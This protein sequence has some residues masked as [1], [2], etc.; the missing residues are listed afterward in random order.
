VSHPPY[1]DAQDMADLPDEFHHEPEHAL[2]AGD[3]GLDFVDIMLKQASDYLSDG[4]WLFVEVGNSQVHVATR[5][6]S[7]NVTWCEFELGGSGIFAIQKE[8]L[9]AYW[10][11]N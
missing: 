10:K 9:V 1:V 7:L 11:E 6:P 4:A 8:T 5:F 2:A 3:D